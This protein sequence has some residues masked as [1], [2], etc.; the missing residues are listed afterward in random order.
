MAGTRFSGRERTLAVAAAM[1]IVLWGLVSWLLLPLSG[2]FVQLR[3]TTA[4][5][6]AKL[7]RLQQL[8]RQKGRIEQR[9]QAYAPFWSDEP[10]EALRGA[11]LDELEQLA[12]SASLQ[13][14]LKPRPSRQEGHITRLGVE[15][16]VD[17]TQD[18]LLAFLDLLLKQPSLYEIDRIRIST[19]ASKEFPLRA[20]LIVN[21]LIVRTRS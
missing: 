10:E 11:F 21:K 19:S 4:G 7:E 16:E 18:R 2:R 12:A 15:L 1:V 17:A 8:A 6:L 13:L 20:A 9:A 5:A 14:N 3:E